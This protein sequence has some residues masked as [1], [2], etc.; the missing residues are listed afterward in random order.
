MGGATPA[1][2][3]ARLRVSGGPISSCAC[4]RTFILLLLDPEDTDSVRGLGEGV[5]VRVGEGIGEVMGEAI[6]VM[7]VIGRGAD[8]E[9]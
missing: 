7:V 2:D 9:I 4:V 6:E 8:A 5:A 1:I 3:D